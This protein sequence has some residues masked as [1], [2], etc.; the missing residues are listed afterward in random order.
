MQILPSGNTALLLIGGLR[1]LSDDGRGRGRVR[2]R[3]EGDRGVGRRKRVGVGDGLGAAASE[4][5]LTALLSRGGRVHVSRFNRS[6]IFPSN[7]HTTKGLLL[8]EEVLVNYILRIPINCL[9]SRT[10]AV[11]IV[12]LSEDNSENLF[13]KQQPAQPW[14]IDIPA[15]YF[16][17]RMAT[18]TKYKH[19]QRFQPEMRLAAW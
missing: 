3:R 8:E 14:L 1:A 19:D 15:W 4:E 6:M 5:Q 11:L 17:F 16:S 18:S 9:R 10:A 12:E 13:P 2:A 7:L